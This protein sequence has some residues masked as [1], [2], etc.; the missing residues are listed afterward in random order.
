M[1]FWERYI[2]ISML[3]QMIEVVPPELM[4][5]GMWFQLI[6][7][8]CFPTK[9]SPTVYGFKPYKLNGMNI[10]FSK[11]PRS[12]YNSQPSLLWSLIKLGCI[13]RHT[14]HF[15]LSNK[16]VWTQ[17]CF[18][19][20]NNTLHCPDEVENTLL[21]SPLESMDNWWNVLHPLKEYM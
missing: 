12:H 21:F 9:F 20:R 18:A 6:S 10:S 5:Y 15:I 7:S 11:R 16:H 19:P 8:K 13:E 1:I 17:P 2:F 14:N 3:E 4:V